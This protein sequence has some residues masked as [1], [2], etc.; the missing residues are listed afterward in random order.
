MRGIQYWRRGARGTQ[1]KRGGADEKDEKGLSLKTQI[2]TKVCLG[3]GGF[4]GGSTDLFL[5][6]RRG[7]GRSS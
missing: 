1:Y 4:G 3:R 7:R 5:C 6:E 2:E